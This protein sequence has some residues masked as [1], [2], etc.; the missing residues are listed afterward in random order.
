MSGHFRNEL[1]RWWM[2]G[3]I[4]HL[5]PDVWVLC[6]DSHWFTTKEQKAYLCLLAPRNFE[7]PRQ[8]RPFFRCLIYF[9]VTQERILPTLDFLS[10][11]IERLCVPLLLI[12]LPPLLVR[13]IPSENYSL[14]I[15]SFTC[16]WAPSEYLS[17]LLYPPH[18]TW[19][20][21]GHYI[22]PIFSL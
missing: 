6:G 5:L 12:Y 15:Q 17:C 13:W 14:R 2:L 3:C 10:R 9:H 4:F 20:S 19:K 21:A 22:S 11:K 16:R 8:K 7:V 18:S 1:K